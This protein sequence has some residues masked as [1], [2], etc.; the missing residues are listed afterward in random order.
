MKAIV[1]QEW[2]DETGSLIDMHIATE[3]PLA[4]PI[5]SKIRLDDEHLFAVVKDVMLD[6]ADGGTLVV[7]LECSRVAASKSELLGQGWVETDWDAHELVSSA[8]EAKGSAAQGEAFRE[9]VAAGLEDGAALG[10]ATAL[11][12]ARQVITPLFGLLE[13]RESSS[14][15]GIREAAAKAQA[16]MDELFDSIPNG[17]PD[18]KAEGLGDLH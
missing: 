18:A 3:L 17:Y 2:H 4:P 11:L 16:A 6:A 14:I 1:C 8:V 15:T 9:G 7:W 12:K 13:D 10:F 5:G